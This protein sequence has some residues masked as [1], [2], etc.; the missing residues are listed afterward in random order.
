[1]RLVRIALR[2]SRNKIAISL[3]AAI[4]NGLCNVSILFLLSSWFTRIDHAIAPLVW[5][6][7][8]LC[9]TYLV[10]RFLSETAL[11]QLSQELLFDLRINLSR[12]ILAVPLPQLEQLGVHR[13]LTVLTDDIPVITATLQLIPLAC[14]NG[15]VIIGCI[16]YMG[17]LSWMILVFVMAAMLLGGV[18]YRMSIPRATRTLHVA[19]NDG[20]TLVKAFHDLTSG[21]K[22]LKLH[23]E[24]RKI[25]LAKVLE[26]TAQSLKSNNINGLRVYSAISSLCQTLLFLTL[27]VILFV[28]PQKLQLERSTLIG[29]VLTIFYMVPPLQF[30]L[31]ILPN[32]GRAKVAVDT[33]ERLNLSL[34][35][36]QPEQMSTMEQAHHWEKLKLS[37]V[38]HSY[39]DEEGTGSFQVGPIDLEFSPGAL[40]FIAGG[41]GS[42]K[43]TFAKLLSG[44]YVPTSGT[45]QINNRIVTPDQLD[46][47]RQYFTAIFSDFHLFESL[48]GLEA[49]DI[50]D[51][52][53]EYLKKLRLGDKVAVRNGSF[54]TTNLSHGQRKRL[55]LLNAYLENRAI[56]I[57]DEWAADQDPS[58]KEIFYFSILPQLKNTR[59]TV[60]VISHDEKYFSVAD[61]IIRLENGKVVQD[62]SQGTCQVIQES[63]HS[64][65]ADTTLTA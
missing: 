3:I 32:Y 36:S 37:G 57:F 48:F 24:R 41:N 45:I 58:F 8:A 53:L 38:T 49:P 20:E 59:R 4:I 55:A 62:I 27:G 29:V 16:L 34:S 22:E 52:A 5:A 51:R 47:Y 12:Q 33:I 10:S 28:L 18:A 46:I 30:I 19:R 15:I 60:F 9:T 35:E 17:F 6:L 7:G 26:S 39:V 21:I 63:L 43:T 13:L 65:S 61:R 42:G 1:M 31:S 56:Y 11:N 25:F 40:I 50:D 44:L 14:I 54:S 2:Q 23:Q 64:A